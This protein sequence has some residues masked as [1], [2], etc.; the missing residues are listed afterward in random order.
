MRSNPTSLTAGVL[1]LGALFAVTLEAQT[2]FGMVQQNL[3]H[4]INLP[5]DS[6]VTLVGDQWDGSVT[7]V[8]GGAY[9]ID[10]RV[11]LSL[12]NAG[13]RRIRAITLSVL[14]QEA[15]PGGKGSIAVPSLDVAPGE[16]FP[17]RGALH[18]IRPVGDGGSPMVE[19]A[20]DGIL[21]EDL[22]F[23]GP[24][25]LHSRRAMMVWE[26]EARRDRQYLKAA[27]EQEGPERLKKEMLASVSRDTH[28]NQFGVQV[29]HGHPTN[30][31]PDREIQVAF[32]QMPESQ[33][34]PIGGVARMAGNE[35]EAPRLV[36]HNRSDRFVRYFE[37]AW[38]VKD[39]QGREFLAAS[40][41]SELRLPPRSSTQILEKDVA[42]HF[43]SRI[44]VDSMTGFIS[45]VEYNDGSFW[46]PSR[47]AIDDSP[48]RNVVAPSPEQQRLNQIYLKRG[49]QGV[50]EELKRF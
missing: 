15:V 16:A 20:V 50:M 48:L 12:R 2:P 23:Y 38:V 42:L 19:V 47:S 11:A 22:T 25:Q 26:L 17:V 29:I 34:E 6:P 13:K 7:T 41:P 28:R 14:A 31:E 43:D 33:L 46:I 35:A 27:L 37:I 32:V 10:L 5:H 49:V 18:L 4:R 21:F 45:N 9:A 3:A 39:Q 36:V 44:S 24:D 8:R 30:T 1:L 40:M